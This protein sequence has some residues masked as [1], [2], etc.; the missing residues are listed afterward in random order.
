MTDEELATGKDMLR[1]Y[2]ESRRWLAPEPLVSELPAAQRDCL[3]YIG[4]FPEQRFT[5]ETLAIVL[6]LEDLSVRDS[7]TG[8]M[9]KGYVSQR[10]ESERSQPLKLS[11]KGTVKYNAICRYVAS[12]TQ[13]L[14]LHR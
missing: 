3:L 13:L 14:G 12:N 10:Q 6:G 4:S 8:L 11:E 9:E 7:V 1:N 2:I 5:E